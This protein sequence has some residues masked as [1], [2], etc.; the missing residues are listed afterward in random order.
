VFRRPPAFTAARL[1]A[2]TACLVTLSGCGGSTPEARTPA[3]AG[4]GPH[5]NL[6][7]D[8]F[9]YSPNPLTVA[10]RTIVAVTNKDDTAHTVTAY[11]GAFS[12]GDIGPL[13]T[14]TFTVPQTP[15]SYQYRCTIHPKMVASLVVR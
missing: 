13:T 7:I 6:T 4:T 3:G 10:P 2:V 1:L 11:G 8:N 14:V 9:L 15:G 12:T 5:V